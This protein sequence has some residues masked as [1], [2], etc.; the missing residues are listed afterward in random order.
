MARIIHRK[1][2]SREIQLDNGDLCSLKVEINSS[3]CGS[4]AELS[5]M[6]RECGNENS[7]GVK[8]SSRTN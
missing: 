4:F 8:K 3:I 2:S 5:Y 7:P 1:S 6:Y